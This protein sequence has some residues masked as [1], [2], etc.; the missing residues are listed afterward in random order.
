MS[1]GMWENSPQMEHYWPFIETVESGGRVML[2]VF[3]GIYE[4]R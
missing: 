1:D 3:A 2:K 4:P